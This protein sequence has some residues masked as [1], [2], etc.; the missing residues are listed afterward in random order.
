MANAWPFSGRESQVSAI[1]AAA[2]GMVVA[3]EPGVG[4]SRLVS[5]AVR[6][7][8]GVAW[9]R[10]TAAAA[11]IPLGAFAPLLPAAPPA[12][13]PL[14]WAAGALR[15]RVL[16]VDDAHLLDSASAALVHHV[17]AHRR[18]RVIATVRAR[19]PA[20]DAVL[21]LWKDDLLPRLELGAFTEQETEGLLT[22]ALGG[23]VEPA[24]VAR[25]W[26]ASL[27]N[28]LYLR[29]LVLAGALRDSGDGVWRWSGRLA[30][31][32]SLRE[33]IAARIG[34]LTREERDVLEYLAF[35]EPLGAEL[36]AGL[37]SPAAVEH[38]EDRQLVTVETDGDR[39]QV[40]LAHPLYGEVIRDGCGTLRAR[41]MMR[42]LAAAVA[43]HG[44]RRRDDVLRVAVWRLDSG[45][46]GDPG[47]LLAASAQAR[48]ARDLD[49]AIRL[50]RAAVEAGGGVS[51]LI[52]VAS[53][54]S[55]AQ[56]HAEAE[57]AFAA[58]WAQRG[59]DDLTRIESGAGLAFTL[60]R[61]QGRIRES[62]EVLDATRAEVADP[63]L[64]QLMLCIR[65]TLQCLGGDVTGAR[66]SL[67]GVPGAGPLDPR[68]ARALTTTETNV[69]FAEGRAT[70]CLESV[71]RA[72]RLLDREPDAQPSMLGALLDSGAQAHL[73]LGD[74]PAAE[75]LAGEG[76]AL[77]GDYG[78]WAFP[79]L[80][81][82]ALK[83]QVLR[84]RGRVAD[85]RATAADAVVR[86]P[87]GSAV[88]MSCL[89]ELA[90]AQ[91][92]LGAPGAAEATLARARALGAERVE[93]PHML[94]PLRV[95]HVW[96]A[97][98][99]GDLGGAVE[100]ALRLAETALPCHLPHVLHDLVRLGRPDLAADRLAGLAAEGA[101]IPLYARH[102][103][104]GD[105]KALDAVSAGFEELGMTLYAAEASARAAA[106]YR[107][108]GLTR[109]ARAAE[110]RAWSL[111]RRCQGARTPA[112]LGLEVPGLTPRQREVALLAAQG[113]TN[114][115]IAA[116][117]VVSIRTVAN[118][119]YAVYEKTGVND[120]AA[121][122]ALLND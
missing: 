74:L 54:L 34:A 21:A 53:A 107:E 48:A 118:T 102:A 7:L 59:L 67:R 13:N 1:R 41:A 85:A 3:G 108:A 117:L 43:G 8:D 113:L 77:A 82:G 122:A 26:R 38:L 115:E 90:H 104:A 30:I 57:Q 46:P 11:E 103:R 56:R 15:A 45:A 81:F 65:A 116:R 42:A 72:R 71:E 92:L 69:L 80:R 97:A 88:A 2:E 78:T 40:R 37:A 73:L 87:E 96:A 44:L 24:A 63:H 25:M 22:D 66:A 28:A 49:L 19:E 105:G 100:R 16:V 31:T 106:A 29:E 55:Y 64:R 120:R 86:P 111:S 50:G 27:G 36:L 20:P 89:G 17:T 98:S 39:L 18:A 79:K 5:E 60:G 61:E 110:T 10:A 112:L 9:V 121:L 114:R 62:I 47:L 14:G 52:A 101:L 83:A 23:R 109:S 93:S 51:A 76:L 70:A 95:A 6:G 99:R 33:T 68:G 12:G 58:A 91:A 94:L 35:G 119:L 32:P 75:R 4:K 84:L